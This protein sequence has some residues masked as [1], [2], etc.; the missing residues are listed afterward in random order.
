MPAED[1]GHD[2][3][4][5]EDATRQLAISLANLEHGVLSPFQ[6]AMLLSSDL[7]KDLSSYQSASGRGV[8]YLSKDVDRQ[9]LS[10]WAGIDLLIAE[11]TRLRENLKAEQ[12][13]LRV[14]QQKLKARQDKLNAD[15][16]SRPK[17]GPQGVRG[18]K[19]G[20]RSSKSR[21][22]GYRSQTKR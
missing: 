9:L 8:E 19:W 7:N 17:D 21:R 6:T 4:R 22:R 1:K 16:E 10:L 3:G 14:E 13:K 20:T 12:E 5:V 18:P 11:I 15:Q 2:L